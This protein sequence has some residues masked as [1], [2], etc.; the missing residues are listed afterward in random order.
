LSAGCGDSSRSPVDP[1]NPPANSPPDLNAPDGGYT[2]TSE[3]PGFGDD[4][5]LASGDQEVAVEDALESEPEVASWMI[6]PGAQVYVLSAMWGMLQDVDSPDRPPGDG[7]DQDWGGSIEVQRGA[8]L[9][10]SV[11]SFER[12]DGDSVLRRTSRRILAWKSH[13]GV[14]FDGVRLLLVRPPDGNGNSPTRSAGDSLS[15]IAGPYSRVLTWSELERLDDEVQ[16][17]ASGNRISLHAERVDATSSHLG[18][19][20]RGRWDPI[21]PGD[22]VGNFEGVWVGSRG[23]GVGWFHGIYGT[24]SDGKQVFYGKYIAA[25]GTFLGRLRGTWGTTGHEPRNDAATVDLGWFRGEWVNAAGTKEGEL[26][27]HYRSPDGHPGFLRGRWC[28]GD[29]LTQP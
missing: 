23:Q 15:F 20:L 13:T 25:D 16:L 10:R 27:G 29:C 11:I 19:F 6:R 21:A 28:R 24:R 5:L 8:V 17:D 9:L 4:A 1:G 7:T 18:G 22:S 12:A 14:G 2:T 3:A 26:T